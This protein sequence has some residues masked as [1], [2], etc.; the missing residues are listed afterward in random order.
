MQ[1]VYSS[2]GLV[3]SRCMSSGLLKWLHM[4]QRNDDDV[5]DVYVLTR[6]WT[7]TLFLIVACHHCGFIML[8][9]SLYTN[10]NRHQNN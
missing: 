1:L 3:D 6:N 7:D 8:Y 5:V 9:V 10:N 4:R 2:C